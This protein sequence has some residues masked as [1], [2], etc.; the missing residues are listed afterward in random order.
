MKY[1]WIGF[2]FVSIQ[3]I[4]GQLHQLNLSTIS[5][6]DLFRI[7]RILLCLSRFI[8]YF[9]GHAKF[10][11]KCVSILFQVKHFV[12]FSSCAK[13]MLYQTELSSFLFC[14]FRTRTVSHK[15]CECI[16]LVLE[17]TVRCGIKKCFTNPYQFLSQF[18][19]LLQVP[20]SKH[21]SPT[22]LW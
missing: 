8:W 16:W 19:R 15:A 22:D 9:T 10:L 12:H 4:Q 13:L 14:H 11:K 17:T 2:S 3:F 5:C 20:D 6:F 7:S 21:I 18:S 1:V